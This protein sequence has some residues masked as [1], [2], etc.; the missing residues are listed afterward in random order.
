MR[1]EGSEFNYSREVPPRRSDKLP[2][3]YLA[4]TPAVVFTGSGRREDTDIEF[5]ERIGRYLL[6]A[7][8]VEEK[9]A[10]CNTT[11]E[12]TGGET[13]DKL[14]IEPV[15]ET[16]EA[17]A[18]QAIERTVDKVSETVEVEPF[19]AAA[20]GVARTTDALHEIVAAH[21]VGRA[22]SAI[23]GPGD[24]AE[25]L[26]T[27]AGKITLP[28]LDSASSVAQD[29]LDVF[30][31]VVGVASGHNIWVLESSKNL[32][33]RHIMEAAKDKVNDAF[34]HLLRPN[35]ANEGVGTSD[36]TKPV[37]LLVYFTSDEILRRVPLGRTRSELLPDD[38]SV[39][40]LEYRIE[41]E[42]K[43]LDR[44]TDN[45]DEIYLFGGWQNRRAS[46]TAP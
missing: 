13:L 23:T 33:T 29:A 26:G 36:A 3:E 10:D 2:P 25:A 42:S 12:S 28:W 39:S 43:E 22:A 34:E 40:G 7:T 16:L 46:T 14:V 18:T 5:N 15:A 11:E 24:L 6:A 17:P 32:V 27:V 38:T 4:P 8:D 21:P 9:T 35:A 20:K 44:L 45:I 1:F 31:V 30:G 19:D 37:D 41:P